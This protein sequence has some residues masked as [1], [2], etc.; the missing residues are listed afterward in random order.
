RAYIG[1]AIQAVRTG[2]EGLISGVVLGEA[3]DVERHQSIFR[4]EEVDH[5]DFVTNLVRTAV[6]S[7]EPEIA[8]EYVQQ[9]AAVNRARDE[10][11]GHEVDACKRRVRRLEEKRRRDRLWRMIQDVAERNVLAQDLRQARRRAVTRRIGGVEDAQIVAGPAD[12]VEHV[13]GA[14]EEAVPIGP[15]VIVRRAVVVLTGDM[16]RVRSSV[17]R[18]RT[19][20][21]G[22][23][24]PAHRRALGQRIRRGEARPEPVAEAH[25]YGWM[26]LDGSLASRRARRIAPSQTPLYVAPVKAFTVAPGCA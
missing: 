25:E 20:L 22:T 21:V 10:G 23:V 12:R 9:R 16:H 14:R 15:A 7:R 11:V 5:L 17:R 13:L 2:D 8:L 6:G 19:A 4:V 18:P 1:R 3:R 26:V 24:P